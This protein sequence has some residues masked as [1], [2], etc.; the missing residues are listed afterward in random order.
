MIFTGFNYFKIRDKY[1]INPDV[2]LF[3]MPFIINVFIPLNQYIVAKFI[4]ISIDPLLTTLIPCILMFLIGRK[5]KS[6]RIFGLTGGIATGKST[7]ATEMRRNLLKLH[8]VDCDIISTNLR[9]KDQKG[10][11]LILRLLADR[12]P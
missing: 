12:A 11:K 7:L 5:L 1:Q 4:F 3:I 10:Y 2:V 8:V 9:K 6:V